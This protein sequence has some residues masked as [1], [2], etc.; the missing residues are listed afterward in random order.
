M[1][2]LEARDR[3]GGRVWSHRL[4]NGEVVELGG[5][6]ISTS[7]TPVIELAFELGLELVHTGMDFTSRDPVGGPSIPPEEH[8]RLG[9]ALSASIAKLDPDELAL[10]S[11]AELLDSI[12]EDSP[13]MSILRSRLTGTSG[14][15]LQQVSAGEIG[16]EFGIGGEGSYVRIEGG[17]DR[18]AHGL[19]HGL[20]VRLETAITSVHQ[21]EE[22]IEVVARNRVFRGDFAVVA[23]PLAVVRRLVFVPELPAEVV[24]V[25]ATLDMGAGAKAAVATLGDPGLFRRQDGDIPAWYWTGLGADGSVRRAITGFAGTAQGVETLTA[26]AGAR[27]AAAA[28]GVELLDQPMVVDWTTDIHAGGCYSV[29]GPGRR[30][31]LELLARPWGRLVL[32][33]EHV[34]GSGTIEGAIRS[35][36]TAA[37]Q[38]SDASRLRST[39]RR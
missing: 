27:I 13:A 28:P 35:G 3:V 17:N 11:A 18:L 15:P 22:G 38:V 10:M 1:I 36:H 6:W 7:Q 19:A 29:I 34:N 9:R 39:V 30:R 37:R 12:A 33:G 32:A 14:A 4:P 5:E 25:L 31:T 2:V 26:E 24:E 16:E 23:V 8:D 20:D 21:T